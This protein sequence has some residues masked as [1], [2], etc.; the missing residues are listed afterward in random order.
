MENTGVKVVQTACC[1]DKRKAIECCDPSFPKQ[2]TEREDYEAIFA[3]IDQYAVFFAAIC[4]GEPVGYAAMYANDL[5]TQTAYI[6][7]IG[8]KEEYQRQQIGS[9]LMSACVGAA[10]QRGMK[11]IRLEVLNTNEKA[12]A[13]YKRHGFREEGVASD[14]ST[15]MFFALE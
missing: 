12:I 15:Y 9:K 14:E 3:K 10:K 8:V 6:T 1:N 7:M 4:Q 2:L 13:F 5:T 11:V